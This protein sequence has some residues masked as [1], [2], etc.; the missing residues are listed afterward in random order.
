MSSPPFWGA[1]ANLGAP[2][3]NI[4]YFVENV[5]NYLKTL[6]NLVFLLYNSKKS[7]GANMPNSAETIER[8]TREL[9]QQ[10]FYLEL[11]NCKTMEDFQALTEKYK[12]ICESQQ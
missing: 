11:S 8:L 3:I 6:D 4:A 7:G 1:T 12:A 10:K 5:N 9:E 2:C